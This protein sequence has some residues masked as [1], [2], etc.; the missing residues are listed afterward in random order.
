MERETLFSSV[1]WR[2]DEE[3]EGEEV[4]EQSMIE[5]DPSERINPESCDRIK[6]ES[7]KEM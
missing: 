3:K 4:E 1:Q 5:K 6:E 2:K 7:D